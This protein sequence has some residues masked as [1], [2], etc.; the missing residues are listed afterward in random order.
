MK[1][2]AG[3]VSFVDVFSLLDLL[4]MNGGRH[5]MIGRVE[6]EAGASGKQDED[7]G[8]RER[9]REKMQGRKQPPL[10]LS[11]FDSLTF[12]SVRRLISWT[13][14]TSSSLIFDSLNMPLSLNFDLCNHR[15]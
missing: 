8:G 5:V 14:I 15:T 6:E 4:C 11:L 12:S 13:C 3:F 10:S 1:R 9:E 2:A 7:D